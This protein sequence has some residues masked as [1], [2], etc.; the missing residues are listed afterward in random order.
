M[1]LPKSQSK[2]DLPKLKVPK[3][4]RDVYRELRSQH[5]LPL[6]ILLI[7]SLIA[8]PI[9]L[10]ESSDAQSPPAKAVT[11]TSSST[12][13]TL[14][15]TRWSPGLRKYQDRLSHRA[16]ADPFTNG[17]PPAAFNS[18]SGEAGGESGEAAPPEAPEV[19]QPSESAANEAAETPGKS[20]KESGNVNSGEYK[21]DVE[22]AAIH[23]GGAQD[24]STR[25]HQPQLTKL[26]DS[27]VAAFT[28]VGPSND[29]SK[30]MMVV[31]PEV[32]ALL[33][34]SKCIVRA[35]PCQL[36]ALE[37]EAPE[38]IVY[39]DRGLTYRIELLQIGTLSH[40]QAP[41]PSSSSK[42]GKAAIGRAARAH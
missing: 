13:S 20:T 15:A 21:I 24:I 16:P 41:R 36:L 18:S 12:A 28:Y 38:T 3:P 4:A 30:A 42:S 32:T 23:D 22:V 25:H 2:I 39:G 19:T 33:G 5:L 11:A 27:S 14:T 26:P 8:V 7:A 35:D 10:G 9:L 34:T 40:Q 17:L 31:S 29:G 1:K 6:V 37:L